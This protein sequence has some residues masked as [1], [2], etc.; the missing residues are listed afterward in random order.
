MN[1]VMNSASD[2]SPSAPM[3]I[4]VAV[5]KYLPTVD[6]NPPSAATAAST[7]KPPKTSVRDGTAILNPRNPAIT[8]ENGRSGQRRGSIGKPAETAMMANTGHNNSSM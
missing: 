7:P 5:G 2:T 3:M 1:A 8:T 4:E 6:T